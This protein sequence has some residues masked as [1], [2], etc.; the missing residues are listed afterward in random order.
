MT[1][2][3]EWQDK[4]TKREK[5]SFWSRHSAQVDADREGHTRTLNLVVA[6]RRVRHSASARLGSRELQ[7]DARVASPQALDET[8]RERERERER[9]R[10]TDR[11][12]D[13]QTDTQTDRHTDTQRHAERHRDIERAI[14]MEKW[15]GGGG[16]CGSIPD[17]VVFEEDIVHST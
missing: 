12:T 5:E 17:T 1:A 4:E 8:E 13:T 15:M 3:R 11:E 10:E 16:K 14:C 9:D 2:R 7:G 6:P